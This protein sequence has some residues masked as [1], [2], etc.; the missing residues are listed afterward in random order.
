MDTEIKANLL[1]PGPQT[2]DVN[3]RFKL[4]KPFIF[5]VSAWAVAGCADARYYKIPANQPWPDEWVAG[6]RNPG[7]RELALSART[8]QWHRRM[9]PLVLAAHVDGLL[10]NRPAL[11]YYRRIDYAPNV[12]RENDEARSIPVVEVK[13]NATFLAMA[14]PPP[15]TAE[16]SDRPFTEVLQELSQTLNKTIHLAEGVSTSATINRYVRNKDPRCVLAELLLDHDLFF[17]P[18]LTA[19]HDIRSFEYQSEAMFLGALR[20][21]ASDIEA[22]YPNGG[23]L[24]IVK[25]ED[26][27][28]ENRGPRR[29]I[30][31][32]DEQGEPRPVSLNLSPDPSEAKF[33]LRR[34]L[35]DKIR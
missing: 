2:W 13:L 4:T 28:R 16:W 9:D 7:F 3:A 11:Y 34:I 19:V 20:K 18:V 5:L 24:T 29:V 10:R 14:K 30:W 1:Q 8:I 27:L 22:A 33:H 32:V 21:A 26:W 15:M 25:F 31:Q 6:L 35:R 23:L 12:R 17:E